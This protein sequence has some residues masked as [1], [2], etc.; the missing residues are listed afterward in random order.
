MA[1]AAALLA[2]RGMKFTEVRRSVLKLLFRGNKAL[3]AY[4][5]AA[6]FEKECGRR[7]TPTTVYRALDFLQQQGLVAHL[8]STRTYVIR[9]PILGAENFTF[10]VCTKCGVTARNQD[11][12]VERMIRVAASA[13]GFATHARAMDVEGLCR[14]CAR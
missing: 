11:P 6:A 14:R 1:D 9:G 12:E 7:V 5:L 4:D 8:S 3:G 13:I 10:F 2:K